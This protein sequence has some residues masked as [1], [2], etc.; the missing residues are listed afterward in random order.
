MLSHSFHNHT[1]LC[2]H[3]QGS[4]E[5]YV[6]AAIHAG[7]RSIGMSDHIPF[8]DR[9]WEHLRMNLEQLDTY[10]AEV[11]AVQKRFAPQI[12]VFL[13][14][15]C[16]WVEQYRDYYDWLLEEAGFSYLIGAPHWTPMESGKWISYGKLSGPRELSKYTSHVLDIIESEKFLFLAHPDVCFAG[17]RR[18]DSHAK[19]CS[20]EIIRCA[21]DHGMPMEINANGMRKEQI[22][23]GDHTYRYI[24]P[25]WK[26]WELAAEEGAEA[27]IGSD[28]HSPAEIV[29]S[30]DICE[31]WMKQ[32][33]LSD[34]Q[35][36]LYWEIKAAS[37]R[38]EP[39]GF[40]QAESLHTG[41]Q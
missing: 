8:A 23:D 41:S 18:W 19:A 4:T 14:G 24:Y 25:H 20:R 38:R 30:C 2:K 36:R 34:A 22:L 7:L 39:A 10:V 3:A 21:R 6:R 12:E 5:A 35:Q 29:D 26:F 1:H 9:R 11:L 16:E 31:S 28:A 37:L 40:Q 32:L 15:E 13:G 17:Y 33:E 27:V